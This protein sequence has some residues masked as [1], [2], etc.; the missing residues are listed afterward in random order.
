MFRINIT[1]KFSSKVISQPD[2]KYQSNIKRISN[3]QIHPRLLQSPFCYY[4]CYKI[5]K[6]HL[7]KRLYQRHWCSNLWD[8]SCFLARIG[9]AI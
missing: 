8:H 2:K 6:H 5:C 4:D 9:H 1:L 3:D 7:C